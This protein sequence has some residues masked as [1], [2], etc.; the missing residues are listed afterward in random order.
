MFVQRLGFALHKP[1]DIVAKKGDKINEMT[2]FIDGKVDA[3]S[4]E[5]GDQAKLSVLEKLER[6]SSTYIKPG[7]VRS[8]EAGH[9]VGE[10]IFSEETLEMPYHLQCVKRCLTLSLSKKDF[11]EVLYF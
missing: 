7:F 2:M 8:Y 5:P 10:E 1:G 3:T 6:E 11:A 9:S 4:V